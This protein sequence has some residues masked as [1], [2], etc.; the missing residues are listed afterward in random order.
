MV[1]SVEN[2]VANLSVEEAAAKDKE[3]GDS[4][5][6]K[7]VCA[8]PSCTKAATMACPKC[9]ALKVAAELGT[10]FC[11]QACFQNNW[12]EH[13]K[14][15]KAPSANAGLSKE[16]EP[17]PLDSTLPSEFRSYKFTGPLRP[18]RKTSQMTVPK[19][20]QRPDY[21][22][23]PGGVPRGEHAERGSSVIRVYKPKEIAGIREACRIGREVLDIAGKAVKAGV[24]TNELDRIVF[25][26][27]M[28][29]EA[30]PSPLNYYRF[31]KSVCT[32]VNEVICHGI[33]D[34]R[35]LQDG[36]I[37][38]IDISTFYRGYHGDLNET[39]MVG[40]VD[41][42]GK[43]LVKC[44]FD[45]LAAAIALLVPNKTMYR[46]IGKVISKVASTQGCSVVKTYC[47]HGIGE[48]FHTNPNVP[49]YA[50]NKAKG[51]VKPGHIFTIEP[52]INL[53][54]WQCETWPDDWSAVT[55]DGSR[56][57]QFEHTMLVTDT[58]IELLTARENEPVMEWKEELLQ[59]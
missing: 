38:N 55:L 10:L 29:R 11:S 24:T 40:N 32:S 23:H 31:P 26:A 14:V 33:P 57:A 54:S 59:R 15:H 36:D 48:L 25:E 53:G 52:M 27:C 18:Y 7:G 13:K 28:E 1:D 6:T 8:A 17:T 3:N 41:A 9:L 58:G 5:S 34:M 47:G 50:K 42:E 22:D 19:T 45:C 39:F 49:H 16:H 21:A 51:M 20:V 44:A 4:S 30:Y 35:E 37:V 2:G 43:K 12:S 56:S 46:D